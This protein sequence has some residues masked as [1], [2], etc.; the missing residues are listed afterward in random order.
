MTQSGHSEARQE[1]CVKGRSEYQ[2]FCKIDRIDQEEN[3]GSA[4]AAPVMEALSTWHPATTVPNAATL[5][6][7]WASVLDLPAAV[8]L[9]AGGA[10]SLLLDAV[11]DDDL[12]LDDD[13]AAIGLLL[14]SGGGGGVGRLLSPQ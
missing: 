12:V 7:A 2:S 14:R 13:L 9:P 8:G 10:V 4:P 3:S 11:D 5:G 1:G 6:P